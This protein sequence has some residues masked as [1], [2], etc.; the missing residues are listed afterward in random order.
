MAGTVEPTIVFPMVDGSERVA[1]AF[2]EQRDGEMRVGV[3]EIERQRPPVA[4][5]RVGEAILLT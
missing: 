2:E 1:A 5:E 3:T 4:L